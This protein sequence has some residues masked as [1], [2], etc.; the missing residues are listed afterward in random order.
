MNPDPPD[1]FLRAFAGLLRGL[2]WSELVALRHTF[3]ERLL[4][5]GTIALI[6]AEMR[7]RKSPPGSERPS[8]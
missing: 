7:T 8:S 6:D 2:E 3:G 4:D 5:S 1:N